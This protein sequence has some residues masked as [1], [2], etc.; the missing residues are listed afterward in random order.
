MDEDQ[1]R[2]IEGLHQPLRRRTP[3]PGTGPFSGRLGCVLAFV[4]LF[5]LVVILYLAFFWGRTVPL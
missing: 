3:V 2:Q 5:V 4:S 1:R